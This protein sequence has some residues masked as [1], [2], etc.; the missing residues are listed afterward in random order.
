MERLIYEDV[1]AFKR[2]IVNEVILYLKLFT[3]MVSFLLISAKD[4]QEYK[5][6]LLDMMIKACMFKIDGVLLSHVS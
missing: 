2:Y 1:M 6:K 3:N 4:K 5:V